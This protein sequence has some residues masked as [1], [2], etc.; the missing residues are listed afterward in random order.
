[1]F[2]LNLRIATKLGMAG[3]VALLTVGAIALNQSWDRQAR[4]DLAA[5]ADHANT[6]RVAALAAAVATR[7]VVIMG[8]DIRLAMSEGDVDDVLKRAGGFGAEGVKA[9]DTA[10]A[11]A[12]TGQGRQRLEHAKEV[13]Q[14]YVAAVGDVAAVR[15]EVLGL[16]ARLSELGRSWS[17]DMDALIA[18]RE[19]AALPD[20]PEV[21]HALERAD[22]FSANGRVSAWAYFVRG[23]KD[24]G[25]RINSAIQN[26]IKFLKEARAKVSDRAVAAKIDA[27]LGFAP[28]Y[29]ET[30]D[31]ILKSGDRMVAVVKDHA[32]PLRVELD[33]LLDETASD[34]TAQA[35]EIQGR[36][37]AQESR[38]R[39][40]GLML[41]AVVMLVL[42]GSIVFSYAGISRPI[43]RLNGA[44][45]KM[46]KGNL[47]IEVP[48]A[49]RG[50]EIGDMAKTI[51]V[52]RENAAAEALRKEEEAK[53]EDVAR[54]ARRRANTQ[55][56]ADKFETAVG[57]IVETVSSAATELE[58]SAGTLTKSAETTQQLTTIVAEASEEAS[59]NVQSVASATEQMSG[60]ISE[61]SRQVQ[62]SSRIAGDAVKQAEKTDARIN[63]LSEAAGRIGDVVKLIT[64][65]A[66]QTNLL[67]LNA[68][69]EAARAG[70]AGKGFAVVAQEVKALASQTAKATD[71]IGTQIKGMQSATQ[72]SVSAIKEIGGT[73]GRISEIAA[74][75]AAAVEEQGAATKEIAR[76]VQQAAQG[77]TQVATN[78][79]DVNRGAAE[80]GAASSQ[81]LTSARSLSSESNRLKL[82]MTKFLET[83]RAA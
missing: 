55:S 11:A 66:E 10:A 68:T 23:T 60:S 74:T 65:I 58:A 18:S 42:I 14:K 44:M 77:T 1:M 59:T 13:T 19:L 54:A 67:A 78:I 16:Q 41:D 63:A 32:D 34:L 43:A 82:E 40:I 56:L 15:K 25:E 48:G 70:E 24:S 37:G 62:E 17:A 31:Q 81:V 4:A 69:I 75:I 45:E 72:E 20:A 9:L 35:A 51:T 50:D 33:K 12:A 46:A 73:I 83:V 21:T 61:I 2:R 38:S 64:A 36:I 30:I 8:R 26:N 57:A 28:R 7:R 3:G 80:T 71:E 76:N 47:D 39:T 6:V 5:E 49:G 79:T 22:F 52:I 27:F 29:Q 53:K